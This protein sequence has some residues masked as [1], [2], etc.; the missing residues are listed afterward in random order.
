MSEQDSKEVIGVLI[1]PEVGV[2]ATFQEASGEIE[3]EDGQKR[4]IAAVMDFVGGNPDGPACMITFDASD[5]VLE[6]WQALYT[7]QDDNGEPGLAL[8]KPQ[9]TRGAAIEE[10]HAVYSS[11]LS[12]FA[13][14]DEDP[15]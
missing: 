3:F 1:H 8:G 4:Q 7:V 15:D 11:H 14:D 6:P 13:G 9:P 10:A 2:I 5:Y 12:E